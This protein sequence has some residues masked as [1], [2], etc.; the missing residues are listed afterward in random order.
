MKSYF[1]SLLLAVISGLVSGTAFGQQD[2]LNTYYETFPKKITGRYYFSRKYTALEIQDPGTGYRYRFEPR[3]TLNMGVGATYQNLTLN[4]AYGFG[5]L[6]PDL[7]QGDSKYLDLQAHI[8]PK[9]FVIDFFGQFYRGYHV[10]G[11]E[12]KIPEPERFV[13]LPDMKVRKIGASIQYLFNGE[14][15][16][17]RAAFLQNEWQKKSATSMLLGFEMYGGHASNEAGILTSSIINQQEGRF[18]HIRFFEFGPNLGY[19]GTLVIAKRFFLTGSIS[20]NLGLG[21]LSASDQG[22]RNSS[23]QLNP[24]VFL[25]GFAGYNN[26]AWS[27]NVNYVLNQV[28]LPNT[29][30]LNPSLFTGNY[31]FNFIYRFDP[32]PKIKRYLN[33]IEDKRN[34]VLKR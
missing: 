3:S 32:G 28:R 15:L 34:A 22:I 9:N 26:K 19:V 7:G 8:Y 31:R 5:F 20:S 24:N 27:I 2:T 16:S 13:V 12:S 18:Q 30:G 11:R 33:W 6:N 21:Y 29:A 23:W 1:F 14:R 17:L 10:D 4:L 25:R